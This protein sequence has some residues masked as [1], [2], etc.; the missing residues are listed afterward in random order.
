MALLLGDYLAVALIP[1][2]LLLF[3]IQITLNRSFRPLEKI[4]ANLAGRAPTDASS[5]EVE[6]PPLEVTPL[7]RSLN[8]HLHR[9][10][11]AL[12]KETHFTSVA[13]HEIRTPLAGIRAQAQ[14]AGLARTPEELRASL[15]AVMRGVDSTSRLVEQLID[16]HHTESSAVTDSWRSEVVNLAELREQLYTQFQPIAHRKQIALKL[17]FDT[18]EMHGYEFAIWMLLRNLMSNAIQYCPRAGRVD[19]RIKRR[20]FRVILTVDDSGPGIDAQA[21]EHAFEKFNRLGRSGGDG[22]GLGLS[23]VANVVEL[24]QAVISL[25]ESPLGGLKV[26]IQFHGDDAPDHDGKDEPFQVTGGGSPWSGDLP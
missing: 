12:Q 11:L 20:D 9:Q 10:A 26:E 4:S 17:V 23:I 6:G 16:L 2:A 15:E 25:Q 13:A 22:V 3:A 8:S 24:H 21:R 7:V 18:H 14:V 19:V 5:I 1:L